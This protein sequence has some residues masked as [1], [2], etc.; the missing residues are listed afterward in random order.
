MKYQ[1]ATAWEVIEAPSR[2]EAVEKFCNKKVVIVVE[3]FIQEGDAKRAHEF[4][5]ELN[6]CKT[7]P[8]QNQTETN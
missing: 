2:L 5:R 7:N 4:I 8:V 1:I 6:G 3:E